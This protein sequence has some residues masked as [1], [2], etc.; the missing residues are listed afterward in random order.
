MSSQILG[1]V[2]ISFMMSVC[3]SLS[4]THVLLQHTQLVILK[5]TS[6]KGNPHYSIFRLLQLRLHCLLLSKLEYCLS[7]STTSLSHSF[8][9]PFF[10]LTYTHSLLFFLPCE[11]HNTNSRCRL[12]QF[13][14]HNPLFCSED[15]NIPEE[16]NSTAESDWGIC[17]SNKSHNNNDMAWK[18]ACQSL[19]QKKKTVGYKVMTLPGTFHNRGLITLSASSQHFREEEAISWLLGQAIITAVN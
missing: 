6:V 9:S 17:C 15:R 13:L 5:C 4:N 11:V 3:L 16:G 14:S 12:L 18:D 19:S 10:F 7:T 1:S 2:A 8:F